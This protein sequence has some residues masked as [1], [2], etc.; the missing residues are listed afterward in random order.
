MREH[1]FKG[2]ARLG[3]HCQDAG[4]EV[5]CLR[6]HLFSV[7]GVVHEPK[8]CDVVVCVGVGYT[9]KWCSP[10]QELI[11]EDS[12]S[13]DIYLFIVGLLLD[14]L[15]GHIISCPAEG[16]A[17]LIDC[18]SRPTKVAQLHVHPLQVHNEYVLRLD[19]TMNHVPVLH[20]Y[21]RMH[22]LPDYVP[23]LLLDEALLLFE[24]LVQVP[25]LSIL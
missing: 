2:H 8:S 15:R 12:D 22:N 13:P 4:D 17:S 3:V 25:K 19:V 21:Q 7:N 24:S 10:S 14:Q 9:G 6:T 5:L 16:H 11:S 18:V 1:V 20:V 23:R